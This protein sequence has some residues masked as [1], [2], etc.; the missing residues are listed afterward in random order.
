MPDQLNYLDFLF[1]PADYS[2]WW[3]IGA[4]L[5]VLLV[6]GWVAGVFVW[7]MPMERLRGIPVV[8][9][10]AFRVLAFKFR[11]SLAKVEQ[12][13]QA[14]ALTTREAFHQISRIFRLFI[15][16]RTGYTAREMTATDVANSP[17]AASALTV[18]TMTYPG[19]FDDADPRTVAPT[20]E[21]AR[22]AVAGWA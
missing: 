18:L 20:V 3:V 13:H 10:I 12:Q 11:R 17:L 8:R 5:M 22:T 9:N 6:I 1:G 15:A 2:L 16:F 7:T 4:V 14:R 21:A 19:Q